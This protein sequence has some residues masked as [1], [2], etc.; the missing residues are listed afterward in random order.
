MN[1]LEIVN[2]LTTTEKLM[3]E[4]KMYAER[5]RRT[6]EGVTEIDHVFL[7]DVYDHMRGYKKLLLHILE[8]T[9]V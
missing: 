3:S 6:E 8:N 7:N 2:S 1:A 9:E 4:A 5:S